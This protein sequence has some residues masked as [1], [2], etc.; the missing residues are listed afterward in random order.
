MTMFDQNWIW[1]DICQDEQRLLEKAP[2]VAVLMSVAYSS[3]HDPRT[4]A[5][6]HCEHNL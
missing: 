5:V 1:I 4:V 2:C 6:L 3:D